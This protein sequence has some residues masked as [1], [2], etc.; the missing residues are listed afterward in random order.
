LAHISRHEL[1][2]DEFRSTFEEFEEFVKT[3]YRQIATVAGIVIVVA[4]LALGL[5]TYQDRREADANEALGAALKSFRGYVGELPQSALMPG[6]QTFATQQE[7]YKKAQAQFQEVI[8]KFASTPEPTAVAVARYHV[9]LCQSFLGDSA[10]ALKT[11]EESSRASD[12][13][14]ASLAQF[15]LAG[16]YQNAGKTADAAR[17][18][19]QLAA[20]PT[21]AVPESAAKLALADLYRSSEPK[22]A[23]EIYEQLEKQFAS[24]TTIAQ[25]VKEKIST[26]PQ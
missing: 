3:N 11:L 26:L 16:E 2:Q 13:N 23:R 4:G 1:K 19:Q 6:L 15:A 25:A 14:I 7:K 10:A 17:I 24:N 21:A 8:T 18:L 9:G 22:R 5:K 12:P 20:K